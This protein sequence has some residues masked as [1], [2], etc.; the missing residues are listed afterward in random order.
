MKRIV[1]QEIKKALLSMGELSLPASLII[2]VDYARE[3]SHG[4]FSSNIAL[5]LAKKLQV[6]PI[7]LAERIKSDRKSVV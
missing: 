2:Q 4:D 5:V 7:E 6:S 3:K 1:Q